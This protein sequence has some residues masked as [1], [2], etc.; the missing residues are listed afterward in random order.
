MVMQ[1]LEGK[2]L[3]ELEEKPTEEEVWKWSRELISAVHM[4]HVQA[5]LAHRDIKPENIKL[6]GDANDLVLYDFGHS[7]I[8]EDG[9]DLVDD[10]AGT[11]SFF[12]PEL[13]V[14]ATADNPK[15]MHAK[16]CDIWALGVTLFMVAAER[17]PFDD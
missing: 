15:I 3:D 16:R 8:F 14:P 6:K 10:T 12:S 4:C 11:Y 17:H 7:L 1:Y 13:F 5:K 2:S 9:N